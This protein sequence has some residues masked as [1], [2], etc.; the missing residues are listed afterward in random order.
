MSSVE[1]IL[2]VALPAYFMA[3]VL[4]GFGAVVPQ[5][6]GGRAWLH[7]FFIGFMLHTAALVVRTVISRDVPFTDLFEYCL[8]MGWAA[9]LIYL[10]FFRKNLP[11]PV[12]AMVTLVVILLV[13]LALFYYSDPTSAKMPALKSNW[14]YVHVSLAAL[15]ETFF[16]I[17]FAASL[18]LVFKQGSG[19]SEYLARLDNVAYRAISMGFPI[20]TA[21]AMVA[22]AIWAKRAWGAYWS[23][24][25]KETMSLVVWLIYAIYLHMRLVRGMKGVPTAVI[26][27]VGFIMT[28]LTISGSMLL[29]GLH[30]YG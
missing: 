17:A 6:M 12:S 25:P 27:I 11:R 28:L 26:A 24:D 15:G 5:K 29:G 7:L 14:L 21:G 10:V 13:G 1:I 16:A 9:A 4:L 19:D 18:I 2:Y 20:F 22:G 3:M 8:F 30:S 23:W